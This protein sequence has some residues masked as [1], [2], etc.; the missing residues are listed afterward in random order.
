MNNARI[1][2]TEVNGLYGTMVKKFSER[3]LGRVPESIGVMWHNRPVLKAMFEFGGKTDKWDACDRQLKAFAHMAAVSMVGC[4]FCLDFGYLQA[5]NEHLDLEKAREVPR[6]RESDLFSPLE[7]EV[8]A[9]AEAMSTT[10]PTVT[11]AMSASLLDQLGP[12]G[13]LEL[14]AFIGAANMTSRTNVALGIEAE[15][16]ATAAGL[17]P[18]A[19]RTEP[20]LAVSAG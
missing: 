6:W 4:S 7:R 11:D 15:G 12:A 14:S 17:Q 9:Y 13:L 10:P 20:S 3:K 19:L 2:S 8:M 16:F 5:S 18:L 1:P